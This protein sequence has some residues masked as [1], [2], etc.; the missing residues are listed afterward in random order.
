MLF[1]SSRR[2]KH[3]VVAGSLALLWVA[4][5]SVA[6]G[7]PRGASATGADSKLPVGYVSAVMKQSVAVG[8]RHLEPDGVPYGDD[9]VFPL[10]AGDRLRATSHGRVWFDVR[11]GNK[12]AY[13]SMRPRR[14]LSSVRVAPS[15][16]VLLNFSAGRL[17]CSTTRSGG[18]KTIRVGPVAVETV[19]PVFGI[20]V[21]DRQVVVRIRRGSAI[22]TG[23]KGKGVVVG[24]NGSAAPRYAQQVVVPRG[25]VARPSTTVKLN[26]D[27]RVAFT[28]LGS[29]LPPARIPLAPP[30]TELLQHPPNPS[31]ADVTFAFKATRARMVF[32]SCA[33]DGRP[34]RVC[35]S[36]YRYSGLE[37][38][39]HTFLVK[40]TDGAGFTGPPSRTHGRSS[41]MRRRE[42]RLPVIAPETSTSS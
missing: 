31:K 10:H 14:G 4:P 22:V 19:D 38:G 16:S 12:G 18:K 13:C 36:P 8:K 3:A 1:A 9:H 39:A 41:R 35:S 24:F 33:L 7:A 29:R 2:R 20:V 6:V 34:F 42:S 25:G 26:S 40:A 5:L 21:Q 30:A 23:S 11:R 15:A 27:E 17:Q 32:F 28:R 37:A